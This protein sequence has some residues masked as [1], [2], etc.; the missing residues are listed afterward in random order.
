MD[1]TRSEP[2]QKQKYPRPN[3][4]TGLTHV[5]ALNEI[6]FHGCDYLPITYAFIPLLQSFIPSPISRSCFKAN[7]GRVQILLNSFN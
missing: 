5:S 1:T 6:I 4:T 7:L 3:F 2:D